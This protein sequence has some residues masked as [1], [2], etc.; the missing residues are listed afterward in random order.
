MTAEQLGAAMLSLGPGLVWFHY[1]YRLDRTRPE[2]WWRLLLVFLAGA[3][4]TQGVLLTHFAL[5]P[6]VPGLGEMPADAGALLVF[7]VL[8]VGLLEEVWKLLAVRLFAY[9]WI[10]QPGDGL[11][12]AGISALGFATAENAVY[13]LRIDPSVL[14]QRWIMSTF[15]HVLMAMFW[16]YALGVTKAGPAKERRVALVLRG[17][18]LAALVHGLYDWLLMVGQLP[19]AVLLLLGVWKLFLTRVRQAAAMSP[20]RR[21]VARAV[22]EC[23]SCRAL[24]RRDAERCTACG[25]RMGDGPAFCPQCL[26]PAPAGSEPCAGCRTELAQIVRPT[27]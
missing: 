1:L 2:P 27:T 10:D 3:A 26:T 20:F 21:Q 19:L 24:V 13:M 15:G 23:P 9:R 4:S 12:F 22:R 18:A 25:G 16:G 11:L 17:L 8:S 7:F 6:Y 14:L 5:D